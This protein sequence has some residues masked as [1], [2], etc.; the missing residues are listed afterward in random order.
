MQ[1]NSVISQVISIQ[2]WKFC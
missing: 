1:N 2:F